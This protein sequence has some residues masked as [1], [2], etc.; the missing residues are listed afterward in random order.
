MYLAKAFAKSPELQL[1][2][3]KTK[4]AKRKKRRDAYRKAKQAVESACEETSV[5]RLVYIQYT[6]THTHIHIHICI[7]T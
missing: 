3:K 5:I 1:N 4:S 6:H 7:H 2:V